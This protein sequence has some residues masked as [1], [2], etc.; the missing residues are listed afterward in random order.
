[1][2][3]KISLMMI[4]VL[5]S[6]VLT[7]CN[8]L[9]PEQ[10]ALTY[11]STYQL[12][13]SDTDYV[14]LNRIND[15][16]WVHTTYADYNGWRTPSNG[17]VVVTSKG[18]VLLDTPW[19]NQQTET[20]LRLAEDVFGKDTSIA[21]ITHAHEDRIGGIDTLL[22]EGIQVVSTELTAEEAEKQGYKKP[23]ATLDDLTHLKIGDIDFE[24][25]YPG[26]GHTVDN[27]TI[28]LPQ[29]KVLFGGCLIKSLESE[30]KGNVE[31]ANVEEWPL[32]VQKVIDKYPDADIVIPGHGGWGDASLLQHTLDLLNK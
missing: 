6:A 8:N 21:I 20:L 28:W 25:F 18:I 1:M 17:L 4:A 26:E 10:A 31:D 11:E 23:E 15:N 5:V 32:S 19:N 29:Y 16:I 7:A 30:D 14:E 2:K 22:A 24:A 13:N 27:I 9:L 12:G 3:T